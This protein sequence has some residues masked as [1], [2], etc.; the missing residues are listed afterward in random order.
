MPTRPKKRQ[1]A[2]RVYESTT[3]PKQTHFTPRNRTVSARNVSSSVPSTRQQT[4]TQIDFVQRF[5]PADED[6]LAPI[7]EDDRYRARKR[8]KTM[9]VVPP[10]PTVQTRAA[11]QR[12]MKEELERDDGAEKENGEIS[13]LQDTQAALAIAPEITMPPPKTP[14]TIRKTE[15]PSSESTATPLSTLSR[16]S[17]RSISRSPLKERSS[18][19]GIIRQLQTRDAKQSNFI[20]KLEIRDTFDN[21]SEGSEVSTQAPCTNTESL[22]PSGFPS[23]SAELSQLGQSGNGMIPGVSRDQN[24][25]P[26]MCHGTQTIKAEIEDSVDGSE[27]E[28][29]EDDDINF[30]VGN[31][32]QAALVHAGILSDNLSIEDG[33]L[34]EPTNPPEE[35]ESHFSMPKAL[36]FGSKPTLTDQSDQLLK[37]NHNDIS[38]ES[39]QSIP[40]SQEESNSGQQPYTLGSDP[41]T[42]SKSQ[43]YSLEASAQLTNELRH[44]T[45]PKNHHPVLETESQFENSFQDYSP[46]NLISSSDDEEASA[47]F[48]DHDSYHT[49]SSEL[50]LPLAPPPLVVPSSQATTVDLTQAPALAITRPSVQPFHFSSSPLNSSE[51]GTGSQYSVVWDGKRLTDSQLLPDS[52]MKDSVQPAPLSEEDGEEAWGMEEM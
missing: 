4:L 23:Q 30:G 3:R 14:R 32:T 29:P 50:P 18:N 33:F 41:I 47:R 2:T 11:K 25:T 51:N 49:A 27:E 44:L 9:P 45:Q 13:H 35:D 39:V 1:P 52:L 31:E 28:D 7:E 34:N 8:R 22:G 48:E 16:R 6:E 37:D 40:L 19:I 17:M 20:P 36:D 43:S 24:K 46:P 12:S 38:R 10:T 42:P 5:S 26:F 15:I 21:G